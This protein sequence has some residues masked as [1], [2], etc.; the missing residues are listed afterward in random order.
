MRP[1]RIFASLGLLGLTA[2]PAVAQSVQQRA[3]QVNP[4]NPN[5]VWTVNRDNNSVSVI[6]VQTGTVLAEIAVGVFPRSLAFNADGSRVLVANQRGNVPITTNFVVPVPGFSGSE[7]RG[8]ISVIDVATRQVVQT[9]TDVGTEPYGIALSPNG[10]F[11]ALTVQR[12]GDVRLYDAV[13]YQELTR[14]HYDWN[15]NH[16]PNGKTINDLDQD[17]DG[18][19]DYQ[20]PRGLAISND[21]TKLYVTH[22]KSPWITILN[23]TLDQNGLPTG[24]NLAHAIN[25]DVYP[26]HPLNNPVPVQ[27]VKS[28][29]QPRFSGDIDVKADGSIALVPQQLANA[30]HDVNHNFG[31]GFPGAFANRIY[32]SLTAIDLIN[33]SFGQPNDSSFRLEHELSDNDKPAEYVAYGPQGKK[34]GNGVATLGGIG[35][36]ILGGNVNVLLSGGTASML[37]FFWLGSEVNL[38]LPQGTLLATL[39]F[40]Y[41]MNSVGNGTFN[42]GFPVPNNPNLVGQHVSTQAAL[43]DIP[44]GEFALSNGLRIAPGVT[45][46]LN[47]DMGRRGALP[48]KVKFNSA[49]NRV[50]MLNRG[51]EDIFVYSYGPQGMKMLNVYPPRYAFQERAPFDLSTGLG[52]T[53]L[54]WV[55]VDDPSTVN[56]DAR[57]FVINE[58]SRSLSA[59]RIDWPTGIIT[60]ERNQIPTLLGPDL[61]TQSENIGQEL[62]EDGSRPQTT[63]GFNNSCVSCHYEGGEDGIAWQRDDGPK[64]TMPTYGGPL[65]TG[66]LLWKGTRVNMAETG[67]MFG[68]ENG[69][70]GIFTD[71]EQQGLIDFHKVTP[72][73]LN[74]FLDPTTGQLTAQA[75]LGR[76]LFFGSNDT[77]LNPSGRH[78]GCFVCHP[79]A[80][81]VF[82]QPRL[83]TADVVDPF[84]AENLEFGFIWDDLCISLQENIVSTNLR[85]VNSAVNEDVDGDGFPEIDRNVDGYSDIESYVPMNVD[86]D[87]DFTRDDPNSYPC[88]VDPFFDPNGP[89]KVF[90]RTARNYSIPTKLGAWATGPYMH[91]HATIALRHL[92]DPESQM[93]DPVYGSNLYPTL[94]KFYNEFHDIRGHSDL[95]PNSSKV[96]LTLLSTNVQADIEAIL[97]FVESL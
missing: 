40:F 3:V 17:H 64:S 27:V 77:G 66:L 43:Y 8:S 10:K 56:D 48:S 76:D 5:E 21:S 26:F 80:D 25:Q 96:Q 19:P 2:L 95:V 71:A 4:S 93:F 30:N 88:P 62:F 87:I 14:F 53:P 79:E 9:L 50:V 63:G 42:F 82:G 24:V 97:A 68:G 72:F 37:G 1:G 34:I 54:G 12:T 86:K 52:D 44:S 94:F 45:G 36:P 51:S 65:G 31:P 20:T 29:G 84:Y 39:D 22:L 85:N 73:P 7:V 92:L 91:D 67:P 61:F 46:Y 32:P 11:F 41:V 78:A 69:G 23:V 38:P 16:I 89:K 33:N 90:G 75:K 28:Q 74:P 81:P 15:L 47:G 58:T 6:N 13:T 70:T 55:V 57:I 60:K 59:L 18:L 83:Y 49:G 35:S